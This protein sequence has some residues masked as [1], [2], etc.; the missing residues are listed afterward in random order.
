MSYRCSTNHE[1][2]VRNGLGDSFE[3][4]RG[5]KKRSRRHRRHRFPK[6]YLIRIDHS[7]SLATEILH[8]ARSGSDIK[9]VTG[10]DQDD[11]EVQLNKSGCSRVI[12]DH[13][14]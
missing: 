12:F 13:S 14:G 8:G 11:N 9:R 2:A 6:C 1:R 4:L 7:E 10:R 5:L 3:L